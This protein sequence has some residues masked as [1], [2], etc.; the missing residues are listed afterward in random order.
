MKIHE[1][2]AAAGVRGIVSRGWGGL[3]ELPDGA[4]RPAAVLSIGSVPHDWLFPRCSGVET[5]FTPNPCPHKA[6]P[7]QCC[8]VAL[9]RMTG[10]S[11][12]AQ[13]CAGTFQGEVNSLCALPSHPGVTGSYDSKCVLCHYT[14]A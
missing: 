1:A 13:V 8:L 11:R 4:A 3:G 7:C 9:C 10:W 12:P 2:V 5:C 6:S 14:I